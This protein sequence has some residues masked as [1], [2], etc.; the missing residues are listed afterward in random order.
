MRYQISYYKCKPLYEKNYKYKKNI[1]ALNRLKI[2]M[3]HL[4][5]W[6]W[7]LYIK[8]NKDLVF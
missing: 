5:K 6:N 7:S 8:Y 1:H 4:G 2:F 3:K